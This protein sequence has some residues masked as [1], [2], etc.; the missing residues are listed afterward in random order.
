MSGLTCDIL[1]LA[2]VALMAAGLGWVYPPA[3]LVFLGAAMT[4][5]AVLM[6]RAN[7]STKKPRC[8]RGD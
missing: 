1:A 5:T 4:T 8:E 7:V 3:A 2:G 6:A